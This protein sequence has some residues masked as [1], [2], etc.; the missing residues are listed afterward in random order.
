M[1]FRSAAGSPT[2]VLAME[3]VPS[4]PGGVVIAG[5]TPEEKAKALVE[6]LKEAKFL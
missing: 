5:A 2:E 3:P 4:R 1:L 6:K